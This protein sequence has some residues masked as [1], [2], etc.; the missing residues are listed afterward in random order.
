MVTKCNTSSTKGSSSVEGLWFLLLADF[1]LDVET[2]MDI[3][4]R[5]EEWNIICCP[6]LLSYCMQTDCPLLI[7]FVAVV[8]CHSLCK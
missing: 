3:Q 1:L 6:G 5:N 4:Q 2:L 8:A 7:D